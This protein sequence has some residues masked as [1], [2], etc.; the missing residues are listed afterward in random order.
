MSEAVLIDP[1]E[2]VGPSALPSARGKNE[3]ASNDARFGRA[4]PDGTPYISPS[5]I[6]KVLRCGADWKFTYLDGRPDPVGM[7]AQFGTLCHD[8][9]EAGWINQRHGHTATAL[10]VSTWA[11]RNAQAWITEPE[12]L[13]TLKDAEEYAS[14][15][16]RDKIIK[17]VSEWAG[18]AWQWL[19]DQGFEPLSVEE[20]LERRLS[21]DGVD[22]AYVGYHDFYG[23]HPERGRV[24]MD[25]KFPAKSPSKK[26]DGFEARRNYIHSGLSYA[27]TLIA[28]GHP[29]DWICV[30]HVVRLKGGPK[31]CPAWL[32]V[33]DQMIAWARVV[34]LSGIRKILREDTDPDPF[35]ADWFCG[36][37]WCSHYAT[38]PGSTLQ[39][40]QNSD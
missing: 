13:A 10:G 33:T 15:E 19:Q 23:T 28:A 29:V 25:Y 5:Q 32:R 21:V 35:S 40:E 1:A 30:L 36:P 8:A 27:D 3:H 9:L 38:C 6:A 16:A 11:Q 17:D 12:N 24:V 22:V 14:E 39:V 18:A 26:G 37:K 20:R 31:V 34:T 2:L 4:L 7:S